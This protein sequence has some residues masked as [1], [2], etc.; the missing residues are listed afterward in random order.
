M[1]DRYDAKGGILAMTFDSETVHLI[2]GDSTRGSLR[3][4]FH[5]K[6][7]SIVTC[8]DNLAL[9][10]QTL[11][12]S[13]AEWHKARKEA[14]A[15]IYGDEYI[16]LFEDGDSSP[17]FENFELLHNDCPI[18]IWADGLLATQMMIAFMCNHLITNTRP[19]DRLHILRYSQPTAGFTFAGLPWIWPDELKRQRPETQH[20]SP[21]EVEAYQRIW[22]LFI[23]SKPADHLALATD[24]D[25]KAL[26]SSAT[27]PLIRRYPSKASGFTGVETELVEAALKHEPTTVRIV[28]EV[29]GYNETPDSFGDLFLYNRLLDMG[30]DNLA[31]PLFRFEFSGNKR[32]M[33]ACKTHVLPIAHEILAGRKNMVALNGIDQWIGGVH[34]T[35]DNVVWR[36]DLAANGDR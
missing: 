33:R 26:A 34:L 12:P 8:R 9:G 32:H 21:Q 14:L 29:M 28:A 4:A 18:L 20:L 6:K 30:A 31:H 17:C 13:Y 36:E 24:D 11:T 16:E 23:S 22:L 2:C 19:A 35:P 3:Q 5:L 10:R 27:A 15:D 25:I 1:T 7:G